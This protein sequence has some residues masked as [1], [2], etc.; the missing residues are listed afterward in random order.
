VKYWPLEVWDQLGGPYMGTNF[1]PPIVVKPSSNY[2]PPPQGDYDV[3]YAPLER[4][5]YDSVEQA[6][7]SCVDP[8]LR[9]LHGAQPSVLV[10]VPFAE[11]FEGLSGSVF[12]SGQESAQAMVESGKWNMKGQVYV[13]DFDTWLASEGYPLAGYDKGDM[14]LLLINGTVNL[15]DFVMSN[16]RNDLMQPWIAC[17]DVMLATNE[18]VTALS[19]EFGGYREGMIFEFYK[20]FNYLPTYGPVMGFW[21]TGDSSGFGIEIDTR[22]TN[23]V[24]F[25]GTNSYYLDNEPPAPHFAVIYR[26]LYTNWLPGEVVASTQTTFTELLNKWH[27]YCVAVEPKEGQ[28]VGGQ[29]YAQAMNI[30]MFEV[31]DG[32]LQYVTGSGSMLKQQ[33]GAGT[34][35]GSDVFV[36][37]E[38]GKA[39]EWYVYVFKY[40]DTSGTDVV[41]SDYN[42]VPSGGE[43]SVFSNPENAIA[44]NSTVIKVISGTPEDISLVYTNGT[45]A[46]NLRAYWLATKPGDGVT[47]F[48]GPDKDFIYSWATYVYYTRW[49]RWR[50][51]PT[52][53]MSNFNY[54]ASNVIW[55]G[56]DVSPT[57]TERSVIVA[58]FHASSEGNVVVEVFGSDNIAVWH[59]YQDPA[60]GQWQAEPVSGGW[61]E[62]AYIPREIWTVY[63][64]PGTNYI[65]VQWGD[66]GAD[67]L[68]TV[69]IYTTKGKIPWK[70]KLFYDRNIPNCPEN[71]GLR[72]ALSPDP[73]KYVLADAQPG[74]PL[75]EILK[76]YGSA[77]TDYFNQ[78][79]PTTNSQDWL[80]DYVYEVAANDAVA[81]WTNLISF[82]SVPGDVVIEDDKIVQY[83]YPI[84]VIQPIGSAWFLGSDQLVTA[85]GK[86]Y[87]VTGAYLFG[88]E[89][90]DS[91]FNF[92]YGAPNN[93]LWLNVTGG[94][95]FLYPYRPAY[96]VTD[97]NDNPF[98]DGVFALEDDNGQA[99]FAVAHSIVKV[100][101]PTTLSFVISAND[102]E[103]VAVAKVYYNYTDR[104]WHLAEKPRVVLSTWAYTDGHTR[105]FQVSFDEPG[106][107]AIIIYFEDV[108]EGGGLY[109][110][111]HEVAGDV[112]SG[113]YIPP[114]WSAGFSAS[115]SLSSG[116]VVTLID[117]FRICQAAG[118]A[119]A[120]AIKMCASDQFYAYAKQGKI[121]VLFDDDFNYLPNMLV[122]KRY[123][124][125]PEQEEQPSLG[126]G[127]VS[128]A[129]NTYLRLVPDQ[130]DKATVVLV[131]PEKMES[132]RWLVQNKP[133]LV[134]FRVKVTGSPEGFAF[135]FYKNYYPLTEDLTS[136]YEVRP[137]GGSALGLIAGPDSGYSPGYAVTFDFHKSEAPPAEQDLAQLLGLF[138]ENALSLAT[139][140]GTHVALTKDSP[141]AVVG[142]HGIEPT[143][144]ADGQW[145]NITIYIDP[146]W[147][148][149]CYLDASPSLA[150]EVQLTYCLS[151]AGITNSQ[152]CN[153]VATCGGRVLV[154]IDGSLVLNT[155]AGPGGFQVPDSWFIG[156]SATTSAENVG[157]V[158]IDDVMIITPKSDE[159]N[160]PL[161][162]QRLAES[163][164][165][166][167]NEF[168]ITY[169]AKPGAYELMPW[170]RSGALQP[171][172]QLW[173]VLATDPVSVREPGEFSPPGAYQS[174]DPDDSWT[175][176]KLTPSDDESAGSADL[177]QFPFYSSLYNW[178]AV[179]TNG[180]LRLYDVPQR[181][182]SLFN[183]AN[184]TW[185]QL[186]SEAGIFPFY[187]DLSWAGAALA[188]AVA[189]YYA[190]WEGGHIAKWTQYGY[191]HAQRW[192]SFWWD[193]SYSPA[194]DYEPWAR[195]RFGATLY[196]SGDVLFQYDRAD[197]LMG[198]NWTSPYIGLNWFFA[199]MLREPGF[200]ALVSTMK[201][202]GGQQVGYFADVW[203]GLDFF[204]VP[205]GNDVPDSL[206]S[207]AYLKELGYN[208][209]ISQCSA[210]G[211]C[212]ADY[213]SLAFR[214]FVDV[215]FQYQG[216]LF[217][218]AGS[219]ECLNCDAPAIQPPPSPQPAQ[220]AEVPPDCYCVCGME[221]QPSEIVGTN[222]TG[223]QGGL[224]MIACDMK[225]Y[226]TG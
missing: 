95:L 27:R 31:K 10:N 204:N 58:K 41:P 129:D 47:L 226:P 69:N 140:N 150:E 110:K 6:Q 206:L 195:A 117:N 21:G 220:A 46:T 84:G 201:V 174:S 43:L 182:A 164:W 72:P 205:R 135:L 80:P 45:A 76:P 210:Y 221:S 159:A 113:F 17:F 155:T 109:L 126:I 18:N 169:F 56:V 160:D 217:S 173:G 165:V 157:E 127:I 32:E 223:M 122:I 26:E 116:S 39:I 181:D 218:V 144:L 4:G 149:K 170:K 73:T 8:L 67:E 63:V 9:N 225:L 19:T 133:W 44:S 85:S 154:W 94:N 57:V 194:D 50:W 70:V 187:N 137:W 200:N 83:S 2:I 88:L 191:S 183:R 75:E 91:A 156:F 81:S 130:P 119:T 16:I 111:V 148:G 66:G 132:I 179:T 212:A 3:Y 121:R 15:S 199:G 96:G 37:D 190:G 74:E 131:S 98:Y 52:S 34:A 40:Y 100:S 167:A 101:K 25:D 216:N 28:L 197:L 92:A 120:E 86:I 29:Y 125:G 5:C 152:A 147:S 42:V 65:V 185:A 106:Y 215:L 136:V 184:E 124:A 171:N 213:Q 175:W 196:E 146:S 89:P 103:A 115:G 93:R 62:T 24:Q 71:D 35:L 161:R 118:A 78:A 180:A 99:A 1:M 143:V 68:V 208:V 153:E 198:G 162:L 141:Y 166:K 168:Y 151:P 82:V 134:K 108:C 142:Y 7:V 90:A 102:A 224:F 202:A 49:G 203:T 97:P 33:Y 105:S 55:T 209:T 222:T 14:E 128:E 61:I 23:L 177:G 114:G 87:N 51:V 36:Y 207:N 188:D 22:Y 64:T 54:L 189:P 104:Q 20:S 192:A 12:A 112:S 176:V 123:E 219:P 145:H 38:S 60:T 13:G 30:T 11:D 211:S 193:Q 186:L 107:Y 79:S 214:P 172:G 59:V 138:M 53:L 158:Y 77:I 139:T 178:T 163:D 48:N